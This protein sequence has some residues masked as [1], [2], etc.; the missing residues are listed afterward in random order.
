MV[1]LLPS[2]LLY[3]LFPCGGLIQFSI[4][5]FFDDLFYFILG[6]GSGP[7]HVL[8]NLWSAFHKIQLFKQGD[9]HL[10]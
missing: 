3:C 5:Q 4:I 10:G 7:M 2:L 6:L 8:H 1:P 9:G